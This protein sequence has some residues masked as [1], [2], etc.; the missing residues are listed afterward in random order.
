MFSKDIVR[1]DTFLSMSL[2]ATLLY[3][4]LGMEADDRGYVNNSLTLC[5]I[6]GVK[7]TA[8][9]ELLENKFVLK[10]GNSL[11]LIKGWR[12]NNTIQPTRMVE[13]K[14]VDDLITLF[15]DQ[16]GSY[17]NNETG[18]SCSTLLT[19][20]RKD[21][22]EIR[23]SKVENRKENKNNSHEKKEEST[24]DDFDWNK[25]VEEIDRKEQL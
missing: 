25:I 6:I 16:N 17:T 5:R 24:T 7:E 20:N 11:Y 10:R 3:F 14:Y 8:M 13:S 23:K 1:S 22:E 19:Q 12:I 15:L 4:H 9:N 21:K 2:E 18:K